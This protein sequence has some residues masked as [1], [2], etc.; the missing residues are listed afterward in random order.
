MSESVNDVCDYV[1]DKVTDSG[2]SL[3]NLKLQKLVYY[4]QAWY[5]A[6]ENSSLCD[7]KFEAW[8]HGPVSRALFNRFASDKSLY[9]DIYRSDMRD[10]FTPANLS[11]EARAHIDRVLS[12]YAKF[13]G[14]QLEDMTHKEDP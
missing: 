14:Q 8:V 11:A 1:I 7:E 9:S 4:V 13:S 12:V 3:S 5:L 10:G 6:F 2:E